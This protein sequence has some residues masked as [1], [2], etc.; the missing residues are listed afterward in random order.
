[1]KVSPILF[2]VM[3]CIC[4]CK[5]AELGPSSAISCSYADSSEMHP[6]NGKYNEIIQKYVKRGMP[7]I[8]VMLQD[9][10]GVWTGTGGYADLEQGI[11]FS[12]CHLSKAA[13]ITK[14]MV[15]TLTL[16]LQEDGKINIDDPISKYID[17][18]ILDK[19]ENA[20]GKTIR[21]L[22][23]HTTGIFDVITSGK[24]YLA[25]I[26]DPNKQWTQ[27]ELLQFAY[28]EK[29]IELG[30]PY[31]AYYSNTNTLLLTMCLE[32][33][34]SEKHENLLKEKIFNPAGMTNTF[35]QGREKIPA[36]AAQGYFDLHNN[37]TIVNMS[38]FITGSGNGYG[39]IY[40]NVFDLHKFID[41]LFVQKTI[42]S[43]S[44]L[45]VMLQF[46]REDDDFYTGAGATKKFTDKP[47][48]GIGHTG[49]DLGYSADLF[50]FPERG[51]KLIFFVNYGTNGESS[52]KRVFQ[53]FESEL[54]DALL[55]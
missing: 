25:V 48:Y 38:N 13:S 32:K 28:G 17:K 55:N 34:T 14:L 21:N 40:S 36:V 5:E 9:S 35:Y 15:G 7:G 30:K 8:S 39:G 31:A 46:T 11:K 24:F 29:G 49:R 18:D 33:A 51:Y 6:K 20:D 47:A 26:N 43:Q 16:K 3:I 19:I 10:H 42:I 27:T 50:Y 44:S 37:G 4:C 41:R 45:D 12:S 23:T 52:L 53:D 1:M 22:M 2:V 54:T